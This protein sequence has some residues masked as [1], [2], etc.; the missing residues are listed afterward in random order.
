MAG[1]TVA[2]G[3][4]ATARTADTIGIIT[5]TNISIS[6]RTTITLARPSLP[7][8]LDLLP[9]QSF[10]E[11]PTSRLMQVRRVAR[12]IPTRA[13]LIRVTSAGRSD[14]SPGAR[15]GTTIVRRN[16]GLSIHRPER[17]PPTAAFRNSANE[18]QTLRGWKYYPSRPQRPE[19]D[20]DR[21][22]ELAT[23]CRR[24]LSG[25]FC[26]CSSQPWS[27]S[28]QILPALHPHQT[29]CPPRSPYLDRSR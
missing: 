29:E 16:T 10:W 21:P 14:F 17:S 23:R 4:R 25:S 8:S 13:P 11:Q 27:R 20:S 19:A 2:A 15:L 3:M 18:W 6:T 24:F 12:H 26:V 9:V 1:V 28:R 22:A 7:V 5:S